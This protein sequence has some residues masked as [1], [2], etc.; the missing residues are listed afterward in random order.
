[1]CDIYLPNKQQITIKTKVMNTYQIQGYN[2][3]NNPVAPVITY[4]ANELTD[5]MFQQAMSD[6]Q[7]FH[8]G[9]IQFKVTIK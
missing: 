7:L 2:S 5:S 6:I 1:M 9:R 8:A 4:V 3:N